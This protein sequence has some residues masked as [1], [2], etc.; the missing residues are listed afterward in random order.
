MKISLWRQ[1]K[2]GA[3]WRRLGVVEVDFARALPFKRPIPLGDKALARRWPRFHFQ[4]M[5]VVQP[6]LFEVRI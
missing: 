4:T 1:D 3:H 2:S 5:E 6:S